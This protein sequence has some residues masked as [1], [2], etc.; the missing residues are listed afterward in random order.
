M[1]PGPRDSSIRTEGLDEEEKVDF[2]LA[3][4]SL[5]P[6]VGVPMVSAAWAPERFLFDGG[7]GADPSAGLFLHDL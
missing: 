2:M 7:G 4:L 5:I 6:L 1:C 3:M